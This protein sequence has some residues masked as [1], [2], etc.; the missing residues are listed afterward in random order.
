MSGEAGGN[1]LTA[2]L[3]GLTGVFSV[4]GLILIAG[5]AGYGALARDAGMSL[6]NAIFMMGVFFALPAQ[7]VMMDQLARGGSVVAGAFAVALTAVRLLPMTVALVPLLKDDRSVWRQTLAVHFVAVTAWIEGMRRLP[8][9]P[10]RLRLSYFIGLGCGF[11]L[12][13]LAGT[14]IGF[15]LTGSVPAVFA[16]ALLFMTPIYFFLSLLATS[17]T[18]A[19]YLAL[20]MGSMLGPVF[21]V[22]TPGL[23]LLLGG[24]AGGT[25]AYISGRHSRREL[26]RK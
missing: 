6:F 7:V 5:A 4:P 16:A 3:A 24:V 26:P 8:P 10:A 25:I 22:L 14:A 2:L 23:D 11:G 1:R 19:D 9:R 17:R 12:A 21:H 15:V 18:N 20:A 13:T